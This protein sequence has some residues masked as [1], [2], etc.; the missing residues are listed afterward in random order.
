MTVLEKQFMES[1]PHRLNGIERQLNRI[2]TVLEKL[3][4]RESTKN[5]PFNNEQR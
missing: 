5:K 1:M 2:A 4:E 3:A